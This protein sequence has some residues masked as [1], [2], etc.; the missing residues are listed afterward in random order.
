[1]E[2]SRCDGA[3]CPGGSRTSGGEHPPEGIDIR[4]TGDLEGEDSNQIIEELSRIEEKA[5]LGKPI[6]E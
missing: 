3:E 1:M 6:L 2:E 4:T 5:L